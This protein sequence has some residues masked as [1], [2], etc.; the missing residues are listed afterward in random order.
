MHVAAKGLSFVLPP[1]W[2]YRL[3]E[4]IWGSEKFIFFSNQSM[5]SD[6]ERTEDEY[7]VLTRCGL[8]IDRLGDDGVLIDWW[9]MSWYW[10]P[11][12]PPLPDGAPYALGGT[13]GVRASEDVSDCGQ[14]G[15]TLAERI[16]LPGTSHLR[17]C[18]RDPSDET[19]AELE[20]LL[21]SIEF[22]G[23]EVTIPT[24]D[25]PPESGSPL[26]C[27]ASLIA[28]TLVRDDEHGLAVDTGDMRIPVRWPHGYTAHEGPDG[29]LVLDREGRVRFTEGEHLELG[30]GYSHDDEWFMPC[31]Y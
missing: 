25:P 18:A 6:C 11:S 12:P 19:L 30:G 7:G 15:A 8:P 24:Q 17:V 13:E 4:S 29:I 28:G 20:A 21:Q 16:T 5:H 14:L 23:D 26:P 1:G 10:L 9:N 2:T 22:W 31:N 3:P 27:A